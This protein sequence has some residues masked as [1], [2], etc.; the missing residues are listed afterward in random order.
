MGLGKRGARS[1]F[2]W[3]V[4]LG[5]SHLSYLILGKFFIF[6]GLGLPICTTKELYHDAQQGQGHTPVEHLEMCRGVFELARQLDGGIQQY[7]EANLLTGLIGGISQCGRE[8]S[9]PGK[10]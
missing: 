5:L 6:L 9:C 7:L 1:W 4:I 3:V 2:L 8:L 10:Q